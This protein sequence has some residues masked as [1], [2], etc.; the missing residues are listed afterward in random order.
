MDS[1]AGRC[2]AAVGHRSSL[3]VDLEGT[4]RSLAVGCTADN[5]LADSPADSTAEDRPGSAAVAEGVD[6]NLVVRT[7]LLRAHTARVVGNS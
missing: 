2:R 6:R 4:V 5:L 3:A 1:V 7:P